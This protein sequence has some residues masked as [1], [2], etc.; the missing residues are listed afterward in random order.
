[1]FKIKQLTNKRNLLF[2]LVSV[3]FWIKTYLAYW[4][5]FDLGVTGVIQHFLLFINPLAITLILFSIS[6]YFKKSRTS[7]FVLFGLLMGAT[8]L[9]YSNVLYYREFSDFLTTNILVGSNNVSSGLIASTFAMMR[10]WDLIYW[11]DI[12]LFIGIYFR[13][14]E[15]FAKYYRKPAKKRDIFAV[16]A[17]GLSLFAGNLALA[18]IDR[19]QLLTRTFDRNYIVKYLGLNFFA[20]YDLFQTAQNSQIRASADETQLNDIIDFSRENYREPDEEYFGAAEGRNVI[21]ISLESVQQFLIDYELEDEHGVKHEVMPFVNSLFNSNDS[22]SFNNFFHQT[23]QGKSSD[24]E[25]LGETSL[26]GLPEGSAFQTLGS[27][28]TF[29]AAPAILGE[30]AGYTSAAFHGN[31]GSF[32]NRTD[33]Y[34]HF[35]YDYFF[36]SQFY[37]V[38]G[39]RS[40]EYGLKDKLFFND[41]V[42]YIEQLPQPFYTKFVTVTNHFPYPLDEKNQGFPEAQTSDETINQYFATANYLDQAVKEFFDYLKASGLYEESIIMLYGDHYGISNMRNPRLAELVG[43]EREEW[44]DF[45]DAQM[46]RVPLIMHVPGV[47]N[48]EVF[49]TYSGQVDML[50]TLLHLLGIETDE[51]LFMGQDLLS[52]EHDNTVPL[53]NGRVMTEDYAFLGQ[54]VYDREGNDITEELTEEELQE[55]HKLRDEAREELTHSDN[56]MMMD[57]LRFY[58]PS[59]IQG[60]KPNDYIY[61]DQLNILNEE[62]QSGNSLLKARDGQS[63]EPLYDSDA[64]ELIDEMDFSDFIQTLDPDIKPNIEKL[65]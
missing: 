52:G 37:N 44:D 51:F 39:D 31:V 62:A 46:Q 63:S 36:D 34:R 61:A 49:E 14:R 1:M 11:F 23:S 60:F 16:T 17:L 43:K 45:D 41:S 33:T 15:V 25:V 58:S 26:Y 53:R 32:W 3:I 8:L 64:P 55:L 27:T 28:N 2:G 35:G 5:E 42:E 65:N 12:A 6:L 30:K 56:I 9:L 47:N 18:E 40:L 10:P 57:L 22:Y 48:G 24:A 4:I 21:V 50:P 7:C 13:R 19:P 29:H 20:G 38:A 54:S 59:S